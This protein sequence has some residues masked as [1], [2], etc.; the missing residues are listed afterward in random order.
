MNQR[1]QAATTEPEPQSAPGESASAREPWRVSAT[2]FGLECPHPRSAWAKPN[3]TG[4]GVRPRESAIH[5]SPTD[6]LTRVVASGRPAE[7]E[8][9]SP[10]P[11]RDSRAPCPSSEGGLPP[12]GTLVGPAALQ[13][14]VPSRLLQFS[15]LE[16]DVD[17]LGPTS[18]P[19]RTG[20][21]PS[22]E[23]PGS[24]FVGGMGLVSSPSIG[25]PE[26]TTGARGDPFRLRSGLVFAGGSPRAPVVWLRPGRPMERTLKAEVWCADALHQS[27]F[28]LSR[29]APCAGSLSRGAPRADVLSPGV[30][31]ADAL[32]PGA[33]CAGQ[34]CA[35]VLSPEV[36][37]AGPLS[38]GS[39]SPGPLCAGGPAGFSTD[40]AETPAYTPKR[41]SPA[42]P[43]GR[44]CSSLSVGMGELGVVER[45]VDGG[46]ACG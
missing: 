2:E 10:S 36:P 25:L 32:S 19:R 3:H 27:R 5:K 14:L 20:K 39:L 24:A 13:S 1:Q 17:V 12:A 9:T 7:G 23:D 37:C 45:S 43:G 34:S 16:P 4:Q 8:G 26:V 41:H 33:L 46:G 35:E 18:C 40:F 22:G 11:P 42:H 38:P 30:P 44:P 31:R 21:P 15:A 28:A 6:S 29:G